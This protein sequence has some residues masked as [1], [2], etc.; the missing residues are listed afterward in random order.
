MNSR[1]HVGIRV[2]ALAAAVVAVGCS[3][4]PEDPLPPPP[5][6]SITSF[7][8]TPATVA[9]PGDMVT[10]SWATTNAT[11]V[12][13]EQVGAGPVAGATAATG[14]ASVAV[15]ANTVFV[16]TA[17]GEGGTDAR[18]AGVS[19]MTQSG[20]VVFSALPTELVAGQS[21][22]LVWYAPGAQAVSLTEVGGAAVDIGTQL[23]SGL[24]SV[25]PSASTSYR[26]TVDGK[27]F[28][29]AVTVSPVIAEFALDGA[30]PRTG[31]MVKLKWTTRGAN[32]LTLT[33][34][35]E[36]NPLLTETDVA[37]V[38]SG[39]FSEAVPADLPV[40][41]VLQYRLSITNGTQSADLALT[42]RVGGGVTLTVTAPHYAVPSSQVIV[43]W[44]S[45][46]ATSLVVN[47]DGAPR[48]TAASQAE[49]NANA[50][51]L[52][53]P[54]SGSVAVEVIARNDRGD[55]QRDAFTVETVGPV[56]F[57]SFTA[58]K[59]SIAA[60]GEK[61]TLSWNV[62]NARHVKIREVGGRF[63][64]ELT[65][66]GV[67]T[68]TLAVYPNR[69]TTTY[70]LVADNQTTEP[71]TAPQTLDVTVTTPA[72]FTFSALVPAG[73]PVELTGTTVTGGGALLAT[74]LIVPTTQAQ[75]I[76]ISATGNSTSCS[77]SCPDLASL[78][79]WTIPLLG[80]TVDASKVSISP[81][82]W[83]VFSQTSVTGP[84][85]DLS[86]FG[87]SLPALAIAPFMRNLSEATDG[88]TYWQVD[89]LPSGKRLVIQWKNSQL[90]PNSSTRVNF[91]AQ[92]YSDG[93]I[94]FAYQNFQGIPSDS[95]LVGV[96]NPTQ[97]GSVLPLVPPSP[98]SFLALEPGATSLTLPLALTAS[99]APLSIFQQMPEGVI[100]IVGTSAIPAG[101]F[102]ITEAN[103][104]PAAAVTDGQWLEITNFT[105]Q[106]IDLSGWAI[107]FSTTSS[108]PIPMGT[109]L[110]AN[111]H[112]V[113]AQAADLGDPTATI[114]AD[115]VYGNTYALGTPAGSVQLTQA[116]GNYGRLAWTATT[117][118]TSWQSE[119]A[120]PGMLYA[121]GLTSATCNGS[122]T[123]GTQTGSP[124]Q[125]NGVCLRYGLP[126]S[127]TANF[128][129]IS[130]TMGAVSLLSGTADDTGASVT[131]PAGEE[132]RL[133][134]ALRSS[135]YVCSNG[136]IALSGT[137]CSASP[138]TLP[139][140][141][142]PTG[143]LAPF[144]D[145]LIGSSSATAGVFRAFRDPDATP[146]T[147][148]EY[149]IISWEDWKQ[150]NLRSGTETMNFQIKVFADGIVEY[151][152]G[153]NAYTDPVGLA[154]EATVWL[155]DISGQA[156]AP[157]SILSATPGVQPNTAIRFPLR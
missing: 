144:W 129:A 134:G 23:E 42:V 18:S 30:A 9:K 78:G 55:E 65:G 86:S 94:I 22:S 34:A 112:L 139:S 97:T 147:G 68:G 121:S 59:S 48:Y 5:A 76:D 13:L 99:T 39:T 150:Y 132:V 128:E 98:N 60:G 136:F 61:V 91:E 85:S 71:P 11:S 17:L 92:V 58:D 133:F 115:V 140:S 40:D 137:S 84:D 142:T 62:T 93:R 26:L 70:E 46:N 31:E 73:A 101:L 114:T 145:D 148:D 75:W 143:T 32:S 155:E 49:V 64:K 45:T 4:K 29:V 120:V 63:S 154:S 124:G 2:L 126:T 135:F 37:K 127:I 138:K 67:E 96:N 69:A 3:P 36:A 113:F 81:N 156:A 74:D 16:L 77:S 66:N 21:T 100:E 82:G 43:Q 10:I 122:G 56:Q 119:A 47:V 38:A 33:R 53:T 118:G 90:E 107:E 7:T 51:P 152:Y 52:A 104:T 80:Q 88:E 79:T 151:H 103:P 15:Q 87:T 8:V 83:F 111:G 27:D 12:S 131:L 109:T 125:A 24:V 146:G 157:W 116:G 105:S 108:F 110:P 117:A 106:A 50:V 20:S 141:S 149:T 28:D 57:N 44:A 6:A 19:V 14:T 35:G 54:A 123:Y 130:G 1:T 153:A 95:G 41:G 25:T 89:T 72:T 102:G